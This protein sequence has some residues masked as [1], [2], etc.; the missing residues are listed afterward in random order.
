MAVM[1][2]EANEVIVIFESLLFS[3][4]RVEQ[5]WPVGQACQPHGVA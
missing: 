4:R 5:T 3:A 2:V 1:G